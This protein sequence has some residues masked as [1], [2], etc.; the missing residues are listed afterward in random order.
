MEVLGLS[1]S[2]SVGFGGSDL[3]KFYLCL[4]FL[5]MSQSVNQFLFLKV[6]LFGLVHF[7]LFQSSAVISS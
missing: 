6:E 7:L 3:T 2:S 5:I 1:K 4:S